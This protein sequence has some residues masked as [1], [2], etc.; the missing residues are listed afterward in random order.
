[1]DK[2]INLDSEFYNAAHAQSRVAV[3]EIRSDKADSIVK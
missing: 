2:S 3:F 1:M